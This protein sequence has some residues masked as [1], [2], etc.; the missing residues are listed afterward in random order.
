MV[1]QV[2][3]KSSQACFPECGE[4]C[5]I[6]DRASERQWCHL[7]TMNF[8]TIIRSRT[9]RSNCQQC[10]VKTIAVPWVD[11]NSRFTLMFESFAV[12]VLQATGNV[13]AARKLLG[14][15]TTSKSTHRF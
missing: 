5:K 12:E 11:K 15:S 2:E 13:E 7:D 8:E 3:N 6:K 4:S 10:D 9:P 1:I 14:L